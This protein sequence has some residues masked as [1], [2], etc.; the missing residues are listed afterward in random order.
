MKILVFEQIQENM[1][2]PLI[3][4]RELNIQKKV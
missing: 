2:L 3:F 4:G 1:N